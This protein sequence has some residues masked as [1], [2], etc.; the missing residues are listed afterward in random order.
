MR[1]NNEVS[2]QVTASHDCEHFNGH[3]LT[4]H[5]EEARKECCTVHLLHQ[6]VYFEEEDSEGEEERGPLEM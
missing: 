1:V 5:N 6:S 3:D 2:V 4:V